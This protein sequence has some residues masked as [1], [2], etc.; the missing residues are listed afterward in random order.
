VQTFSSAFS[1]MSFATRLFVIS[2]ARASRVRPGKYFIACELNPTHR[3]L[4]LPS[5]DAHRERGLVQLISRN[6][7][8]YQK[9]LVEEVPGHSELFTV[10]SSLLGQK[11]IEP[12]REYRVG[13]EGRNSDELLLWFYP[14]AESIFQW[15]RF[16]PAERPNSFYIRNE[17]SQKYWDLREQDPSHIQ[18][19]FKKDIAHQRWIIEKAG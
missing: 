1:E 9:W 18:Q 19:L 5:Q 7:S 12:A 2:F 10:R 11:F 16:E 17:G 4:D 13:M 14:R 3:V 15:W 6:G 8:E